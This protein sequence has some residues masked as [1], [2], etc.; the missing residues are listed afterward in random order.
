MKLKRCTCLLIAAA[1]LTTTATWGYEP[2]TDEE[3]KGYWESLSSE[4]RL[5]E[6]RKLDE[7]EHAT[8]VVDYP[9]M[10]IIQTDFDEVIAYFSGPA[11]LDIA[12]HLLYSIELPRGTMKLAPSPKRWPVFLLG[13]SAGLAGTTALFLALR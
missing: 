1:L 6:I 2:P 12:G 7:I 9:S 4:E 8:P 13:L 5:E 10:V 11:R 3:L